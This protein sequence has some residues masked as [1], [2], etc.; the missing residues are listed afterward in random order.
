M[1]QMERGLSAVVYAYLDGR[2]V[3]YVGCTSFPKTR[4]A[5]HRTQSAW[6]TADLQFKILSEHTE[7]DAGLAAE[8]DQIRHYR[9]RN[10]II[11]NPDVVNQFVPL[12]ELGVTYRQLDYWCRQGIISLENDAHGSGSRRQVNAVEHQAIAALVNE[13]IAAEAHL[14]YLR[15]GEFFATA[16]VVLGES[17]EVAA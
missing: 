3:V 1:S 12:T 7:R 15:S 5:T 10:N 4:Q 11:G 17:I 14:A 13:L 9:P 2:E 8:L 16:V 6:W